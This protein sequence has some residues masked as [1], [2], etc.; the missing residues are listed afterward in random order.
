MYD[1]KHM[2]KKSNIDY[3]NI[4]DEQVVNHYHQNKSITAK[5]GL[6]RNIRNLCSIN[7]DPSIF[8]PRCFDVNDV[9]E[10]ENFYESFKETF[11]DS[12]LKKCV[13]TKGAVPQGLTKLNY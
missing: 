9:S 12:I 13:E 8:F 10:L 3:V 1:Y 7:K 6:T 4:L 5:F 2:S 11:V